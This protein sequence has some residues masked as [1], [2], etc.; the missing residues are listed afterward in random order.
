M[1]ESFNKV[2]NP[3]NDRV[4][5]ERMHNIQRNIDQNGTNIIEFD[6]ALVHGLVDK[7]IVREN[8]RI[9]VHFKSGIS[10]EIKV[11]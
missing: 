8:G 7:I 1:L 6:E 9:V 5:L 11:Q 4:G 10:R 2:V 3:F